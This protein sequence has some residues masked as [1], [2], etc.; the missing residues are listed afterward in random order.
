[1]HSFLQIANPV[2]DSLKENGPVV[3]L[4]STLIS[5]G[6]PYPANLQAAMEIEGIV[7]QNGATPATIGCFGRENRRWAEPRATGKTG[8]GKRCYKG[9]KA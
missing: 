7:R 5:H 2:L 4:E 6:L 3:A 8:D 9:F 1:M